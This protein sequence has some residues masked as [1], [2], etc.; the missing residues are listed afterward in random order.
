MIRCSFLVI[1]FASVLAAG[2]GDGEPEIAGADAAPAGADASPPD[3]AAAS[4]VHGLYEHQLPDCVSDGLV[5]C[6]PSIELCPDGSAT[7]LVTDIANGGTYT[8]E[9]DAITAR[10]EAGDVPDVIVF[11]RSDGGGVL[12]DDWLEWEWLRV[13]DPAFSGCE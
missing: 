2:C 4:S 11:T 7:M 1:V 3:A 6:A 5:N 12:V 10:F 13:E 9:G 8:E